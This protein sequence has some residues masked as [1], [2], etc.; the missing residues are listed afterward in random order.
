MNELGGIYFLW[1]FDRLEKENGELQ[2]GIT[3]ERAKAEK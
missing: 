3:E 2:K 1:N